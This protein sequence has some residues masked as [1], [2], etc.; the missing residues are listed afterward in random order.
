VQGQKF[1]CGLR[2]FGI[3]IQKGRRC[4]RQTGGCRSGEGRETNQ[5]RVGVED[6][7]RIL[8]GRVLQEG[9]EDWVVVCW[10][11]KVIVGG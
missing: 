1:V 7:V 8:M 3:M 5:E 11:V 6:W 4:N 9:R 2:A 10:R